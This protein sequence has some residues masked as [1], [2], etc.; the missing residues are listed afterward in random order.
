MECLVL[1]VFLLYG[2]KLYAEVSERLECFNTASL[3]ANIEA[4]DCFHT[5]K[6][7]C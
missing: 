5:P 7:F 2:W 4:Q 6:D 3:R 1:I